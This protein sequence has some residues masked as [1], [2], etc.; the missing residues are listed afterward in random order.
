MTDAD[1]LAATAGDH[2]RRGDHAAAAEAARAALAL[3]PEHAVAH[4]HLAV[5][6]LQAGDPTGARS[7]ATRAVAMAPDDPVAHE[8][9]GAIF[10]AGAAYA[11]ARAV[12]TRA[13]LLAPGRAEPCFNVGAIAEAQHDLEGAAAAYR[14]ALARVPGFA[15][16]LRGLARALT[17]LDDQAAA[18]EA[19]Q[20]VLAI[21]P[22][23]PSARHLSAALAGADADAPPPGFVTRTFDAYAARFDAHLVEHLGYQGPAL[24]ALA[25]GERRFGRALDLGCGTGLVGA[26]LRDR[27][28][29]L[30]GVDA[31]PQ[32]LARAHA[33]GYDALIAADVVAY[34]AAGGPSFDLITAGDVLGYLGALEPLFAA[35]VPRLAPGGVFAFTVER[36]DDDHRLQPTGRWTHGADYLDRLAAAHGLEVLAAYEAPLRNERDGP[37]R[38]LVYVVT[39]PTAAGSRG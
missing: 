39:A 21:D 19:W 33:R 3:E 27:C 1:R 31:S 17:E 30:T 26:A 15:P 35:L 2:A 18:A 8:I 6:L 24:L 36:G 7:H 32:M 13:A 11:P 38:G 14:E 4:R 25:L 22:D 9:L 5:A 20:A 16:A 10:V 37:V 34:L 23:D 29:H 12:F 28:Q